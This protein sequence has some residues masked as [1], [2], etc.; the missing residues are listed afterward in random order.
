MT[1]LPRS[2]IGVGRRGCGPGG[3]SAAPEPEHG[4]EG[5]LFVLAGTPALTLDGAG[6]VSIAGNSS[7]IDLTTT[8][9]VDI[10]SGA[11]TWDASTMGLTTS[12]TLV[13]LP[14]FFNC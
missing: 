8:G 2:S 9:A 1:L 13:L 14:L 7:D 4:A 5:V 12:S 11:G 10:N 3:G 6:G